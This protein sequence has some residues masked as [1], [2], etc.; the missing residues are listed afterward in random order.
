MS[1]LCLSADHLSA[2]FIIIDEIQPL[3]APLSPFP[4]SPVNIQTRTENATGCLD[5]RLPKFENVELLL[6]KCKT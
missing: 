3:T 1:N 2:Y 4:F 5:G 6:S